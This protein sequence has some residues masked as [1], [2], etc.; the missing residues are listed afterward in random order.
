MPPIS[1]E[2]IL[3]IS[4]PL[5]PVILEDWRHLHRYQC[6]DDIHNLEET[7]KLICRNRAFKKCSPISANR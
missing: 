5:L 1:P 3:A 2:E 7:G 4:D 6:P